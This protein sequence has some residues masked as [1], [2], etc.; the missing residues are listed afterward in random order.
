MAMEMTMRDSD[1]ALALTIL[2][3]LGKELSPTQ[4]EL[5]YQIQLGKIEGYRNP[6]QK[7]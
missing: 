7:P 4:V 5:E 2:S 1:L 3:F 6:Q